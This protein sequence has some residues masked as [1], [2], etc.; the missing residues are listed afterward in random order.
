MIGAIHHELNTLGNGA[1][2]ANYQGFGLLFA[3]ANSP[4]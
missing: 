4:K 3:I 1:E 2:L